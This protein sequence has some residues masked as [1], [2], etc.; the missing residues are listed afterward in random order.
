VFRDAKNG[1]P[2]APAPAAGGIHPIAANQQYDVPNY[3]IVAA[4]VDDPPLDILYHSYAHQFLD[5]NFPRLPLMIAE[6]L[7]EFYTG[8]AVTH[9]GTLIG[10]VNADHVRWLREN[11]ALPLEQ[12]MSLDA[13]SALLATANGS[14]SFVAASWALMHYL[15]S[16]SGENRSRVPA[17]LEVLQR[18]TP[19]GDAAQSALGK[20]LDQLQQGV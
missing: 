2:Y 20:S 7:A 8:F 1:W 17:F 6:G 15:V 9:E 10:M 11:T 19:P 12:Q 3:F 18:G 5:D 14:R 16:G 4:P 13:G